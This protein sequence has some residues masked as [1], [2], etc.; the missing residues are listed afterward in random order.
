MGPQRFPIN[1]APA[2]GGYVMLIT[3]EN[4]VQLK[5]LQHNPETEETEPYRFLSQQEGWVFLRELFHFALKLDNGHCLFS[6]KIL[7]CLEC[8]RVFRAKQSYYCPACTQK[9]EF[10]LQQV[11]EG[12]AHIRGHDNTALK[13]IEVLLHANEEAFSLIPQGF[14]TI[15][16]RKLSLFVDLEQPDQKPDM[17]LAKIIKSRRSSS[18]SRGRR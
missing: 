9:N 11:W 17:Q 1:F 5:L 3:L 4:G 14:Q 12:F 8:H 10:L 13:K 16:Q 7:H 15:V 2:T 6:D 18:M